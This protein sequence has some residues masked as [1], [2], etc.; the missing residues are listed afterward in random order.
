LQ[1]LVFASFFFSPSFKECNKSAG[2][3][4]NLTGRS[5]YWGIL[6]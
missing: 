3:V 6:L 1:Y 5:A 2:S 4:F